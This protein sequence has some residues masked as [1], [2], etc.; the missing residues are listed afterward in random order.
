M[1]YIR[2]A[3]AILFAACAQSSFADSIQTFQITQ[4][5]MFMGPNNGGG[6]MCT[7]VSQVQG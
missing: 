2:L 7:S 3:I 6:T 1:N 4:A 5:T